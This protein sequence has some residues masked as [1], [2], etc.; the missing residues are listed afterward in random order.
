M[1]RKHSS[2]G[3]FTTDLDLTKFTYVIFAV[4]FLLTVT[5]EG[6]E[7]N[8]KQKFVDMTGINKKKN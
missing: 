4:V 1:Q 3:Y 6:K 8:A 5:L 2:S 7:S